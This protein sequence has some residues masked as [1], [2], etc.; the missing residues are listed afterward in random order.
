[1][2][3]YQVRRRGRHAGASMNALILLAAGGFAL[4]TVGQSSAADWPQYRGPRGDGISA[5]RVRT[6]WPATGPKR[7]WRVAT[8]A[9]F[10]SFAVAEGKAFTV[11]AR[12]VDGVLSEVCIALDANSGRELWATPTGLAKYPGGGDS[13]A[14]ENKG[15]DGPRSTPTV[16]QGRVYV[17]SAEMGLHCLEAATGKT[18]WKKSITAEFGG[19]NI[20][21]KNAMSPVVEGDL[22]YVAGGGAGQSMLALQKASGAVVWKSG[23]ETMTHTTPVVV[24]LQGTRQVIYLMQSGLVAVGAADGKP[25]WQFAFPW[26]TCTACLP[27][28]AGDTVFC[29]AGYEVGGAACQITRKG[30]GFEARQKWRVKGNSPLGSL[31]SPP[32]CRDGFLYGMLSFKKF[33]TGPLKCVDLATGA[34][35][36]EQPGF[37]A[38]NVILAGN[39]LIALSDDGQVVLVEPTPAGY[40]ELARTKAVAGKCWSTP[41][42]SD[43]RLYVRST[44]EGVCLD[45]SEAK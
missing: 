35:K 10:S 39:C 2:K 36:W 19:K 32:V 30:E 38:G 3:Q 11:I 21:W 44:K 23:D 41:A 4:Q 25:L 42:L 26:R 14:E 29:T 43:G 6:A 34:V 12:N 22:V 18:I 15:G 13:G 17:Y 9:G 45:L 1:M 31:W 8:P 16:S 24:T 5:E 33:A 37:G 27:V 40:K 7:L 20:G 28:V